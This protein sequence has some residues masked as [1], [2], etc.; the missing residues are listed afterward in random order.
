[1][2]IVAMAIVFGLII[3]AILWRTG[4]TEIPKEMRTSYSPQD[5]EVLQEDLNLRK[6]VGQILVIGI[7]FFLIL[8]WIW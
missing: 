4:S 6:L 2:L 1:M 8:W 3:A 7:A 5:L